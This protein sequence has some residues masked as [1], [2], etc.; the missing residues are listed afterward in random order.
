MNLGK[1]KRKNFMA[2]IIN[3]LF[4]GGLT[5]LTSKIGALVFTVIVARILLPE[6]FGVYSFALTIIL[7]VL[8]ISDLG[9]GST[10][11]RY[12]AESIGK[13][14][15]IEARS[16]FWFLLKTKLLLSVL[17]SVLLFLFSGLIAG[18]FKKPELI[19]PLKIGSIYLFLNALYTMSTSVFLSFQKMKYSAMGEAIFQISK[20]VLLVFLVF[21]SKSVVGIFI[22]LSLSLLL[23]LGYTLWV[24][25]R[26]YSSLIKGRTI[27]VE[28]RRMLKFSGF[29]TLS[30]MTLLVLANMDKLV[31][32]YFL[33]LK[34]VGFYNAIFSVVVG[35]L[36]IV[37]L[38]SLFLPFF[39]QLNGKT[40]D[41]AFKKTF[42][43]ISLLAFPASIGL[44]FIIMPLLK[45][46]YGAE[47]VPV[48]YRIPILLTSVFLSL[49]ILESL[50]SSTYTVLLNAK[51]KPKI[52]AFITLATSTANLFLNIIL[53]F[54]LSKINPSYGLIGA[55]FATLVTRYSGLF[56]MIVISAKKI[57]LRPDRFSMVNPLFA[58]LIMLGYL[59]LF[60]YLFPLN[61]ISGIIMILSA[62]VVYFLVI[63]LIKAVSIEEIKNLLKR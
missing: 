14:K 12:L 62:V 40:L 53:I 41:K 34:F 60:R 27:P 11:T 49:L 21:L 32:G 3:N 51:E 24:I 44:A 55:S 17:A 23:S 38:T 57:N 15:K 25:D 19:L 13:N 52:P 37:G 33:D 61:V 45:F 54:Y 10:I 6:R 46:L 48:E 63:F 9:I 5:S 8:A 43:Y 42:K 18:F 29:L 4:Y 59:F 50:L 58:S 22:I 1:E 2:G 28:R 30:S 36:G 7:V 26:K 47:Y 31:L 16:R 20:L 35:V 39:T 56:L